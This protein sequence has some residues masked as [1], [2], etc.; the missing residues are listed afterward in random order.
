MNPIL[1]LVFI[2]HSYFV[3]DLEQCR[4]TLGLHTMLKALKQRHGRG[5]SSNPFWGLLLVVLEP[6]DSNSSVHESGISL[7]ETRSGHV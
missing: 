4:W 7:F 6:P 1:G 5:H 2:Q 3:N